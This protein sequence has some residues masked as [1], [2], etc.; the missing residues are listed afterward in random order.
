LL[1]AAY[2][3][4][5][6]PTWLLVLGGKAAAPGSFEPINWHA[7][8]ML[9]GY[10]GAVIA[11][12][13]LTA[14]ARW[15][16]RETAV[17]WPLSLLV[18]LW[19]LGRVAMASPLPAAWV[20][21]LDLLFLPALAVAVGRAV[22][23]AK[24]YRNYGMVGLLLALA[25][26][27][28]LAHAA[29]L[30][31]VA[32][33]ARRALMLALALIVMIMVVMG[34]RVIPMFTRNATGLDSVQSSPAL[35]RV[36][37]ALVAASLVSDFAFGPTLLGAALAELSGIALL[38]RAWR[39]GARA[40]LK[41]AMLWILHLGNAWLAA[42]FL[43]RAASHLMPALSSSATHAFTV[44][45]IGSLTIGM[46]SRVA[47]GHTGRMIVASPRTRLT[48]ILMLVAGLLRVIGPIFPGSY[49]LSILTA[50]GAAWTLSFLLFAVEYAPV[51]TRARV[52]GTSG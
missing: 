30:G 27:N 26:A 19:G 39:W 43:L 2:A 41:D 3:V 31:L 49:Y 34:G 23:L 36:A 17:G 13:L 32:W 16:S 7:H 9:F 15:T 1:A 14:A 11:G 37:I 29:R 35:D 52:D 48:F 40:S 18:L 5:L 6:V 20:A 12:F 51:L 33:D 38:A 21:C 50:S 47:L 44:G 10:A 28:G 42:G 4:L 46:M 22:F 45:A 25:L 8:E 24:N